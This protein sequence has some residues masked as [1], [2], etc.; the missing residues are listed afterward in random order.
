MKYKA[1]YGTHDILPDDLPKWEYVENKIKQVMCLYNYSEIRTPIF[2]QTEL[3]IRSIGEETDIVKKEMYTFLDMGKRSMTLRPEG[4]APIVRSYLEH[5]LGEKTSLVKLFYIGP[6]FR[7]ERPQ[8]GRL[9]Q[10]NQYGAEAIGSLDPLIDVEIINLNLEI[11]KNLDLENYELHLNSIGCPACRQ[12]H[13]ENLVNYA[14][15]RKNKL[16]PE[17]KIRLERNPLRMIDCKNED[18]IQELKDAPVMLDFLCDDCKKYFKQVV[19]YLNHLKIKYLINKRLVRGLDYY[20]RTAFEFKSSL[21]GTQDT[22]SGGGRYDLL[23]SDFGGKD[24]PAIGFA[25]G[26]ERLI[27]CLEKEGKLKAKQNEL[28]VF[29][30][31]L[32]EKVKQTGLKLVQGLRSNG[33]KCDMDFLNRRL[34]A[35]MREANR[36]NAKKV[37]I[38]GEDEIKRN[39]GIVKDMEKGG[40]EEVELDKICQHLYPKS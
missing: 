22:I 21:L 25:A 6:M 2:E 31:I 32:G 38:I 29:V 5:N 10:F 12:I 34:K 14:K 39:I 18:C 9:R 13:I 1:I 37:I 24:T 16:C 36:Q 11:F 8:K 40:Q 17:C 26:V 30:A 4:T 28:D 7:Q 15:S 20:T 35:Q 3:F 27:L 33:L 23:V 19:E